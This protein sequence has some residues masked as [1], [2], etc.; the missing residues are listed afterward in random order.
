VAAWRFN[1]VTKDRI[2]SDPF[3]FLPG[4]RLLVASSLGDDFALKLCEGQKDVQRQPP[5]RVGRIE[6]LS[7]GHEASARAL[8]LLFEE[9]DGIAELAEDQHLIG[10]MILRNEFDQGLEFS[11]RLR[12]PGITLVKDLQQGTRISQQALSRRRINTFTKSALMGSAPPTRS[13]LKADHLKG[14]GFRPGRWN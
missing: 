12:V 10:L 11:I 8:E 7:D 14:G 5:Q 3:A 2:S 6:L 9:V 1:I 13:S 4:C